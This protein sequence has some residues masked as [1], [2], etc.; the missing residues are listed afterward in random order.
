MK[1]QQKIFFSGGGTGGSVTPLLALAEELVHDDNYELV[2]V[3][4]QTGPERDLI[5]KFNQGQGMRFI[6]IKSGK[7]R[8]YFSW[9]NF[10]D[11]FRIIAAFFES[12]RLIRRE[13]PAIIISAGSFVSVPLV[14]AGA[15][16]RVP[17]LI[18]QQDIRPGLANQ[19]MAPLAKVITVS[20]KKSLADYNAR[21]VW[22]G[23]PISQLIDNLPD[24]DLV[25]ENYQLAP[26]RPLIL[27][28]GGGTGAVA[29]NDLL[30]KLRSELSQIGQVIHLTGAGKQA[31]DFE[32]PHY[33]QFEFLPQAELLA[34][35][36]QASLVISRGGLGTL[37]EIASL[38]KVAILIPMP[39]SHQEDNVA[40]FRDNEAA[41]VL[42]QVGLEP[43][44]LLEEIELLLSD[45]PRQQEYQTNLAK[46]MKGGAR[47]TLAEIII[48][49]VK[50]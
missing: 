13:R 44:K 11:I 31:L 17:I 29:V 28:L 46:L 3:G 35:M 8:R 36:K 30:V 20:F 14:W 16:Q 49:L 47:E 40:V 38:Q 43:E 26:E 39:H 12:Y 37:T 10:I 15:C 9:Q 33:Y 27:V 7:W 34:L 21:A 19:L 5:A 2:F 1:K 23:N 32:S 45:Y 4:G 41:L 24:R 22:T 18:H 50:S 6:A 25:W 42:D 48:K